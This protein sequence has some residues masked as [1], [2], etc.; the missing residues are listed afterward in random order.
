MGQTIGRAPL[1]Q[2]T[3]KFF[4]LPRSCIYDLWEAFNDIAEGFGLTIEEFQEII[5]SA[6]L[7]YLSITERQLNVETDVVFRLLDN[8]SN[9]LVDSLEFLSCF[10]LISGMT[11]EE[12]IRYIFSMYDFDESGVLT[13]D[14]MVLSFRSTLSG[15]AKLSKIDPPIESEVEA[16]VVLGFN[17][18]KKSISLTPNNNNDVNALPDM[19]GIDREAFVT[20]CL[21][22]PEVLSWIEFFDDMEEYVLDFTSKKPLPSLSLQHMGRTAVDEAVM[23]PSTGGLAY[24]DLERKGRAASRRPWENVVPLLAPSRKALDSSHPVSTLPSKHVDLEWIY[25]VNLHSSSQ[26]L[27]Y[28]ARGD[29][30]YAAGAVCVVQD[31][32]A[33]EQRHFNEHVDLVT[34]LKLFHGLDGS[35]TVA[36]GEVG[37]RPSIL[38]WDLDSRRVLATLR[39]FHR[40]GVSQVDFSPDRSRLCSLGMDLYRCVAVYDWRRGERLWSARTTADRVV[41][42]RFLS[43]SVL[44]T[45]GELHVTFWRE[46]KPEGGGEN[47]RGVVLFKRYRGVFGSHKVESQ[48][49]VGRVGETV[50]SCSDTGMLYKWEGRSVVKSVKAHTASI[51]CVHV[52][53]QGESKGLVTACSLGKVLLWNDKLELGATFNAASLGPIDPCISSVSYDVIAGKILIGFRCC[54]VFEMDAADGKNLHNTGAIV[55]AHFKPRLC[56]LSTHPTQAHLLCTVGDDKTIRIFDTNKRRQTK[57][58]LLDSKAH[59]CCFSS[60]G[61]TIVVGIGSGLDGDP[62][63]KEGA[64][65]V[66]SEEDLTLLYESRDTKSVISD[67]KFSPSGDKIVMASHD[68]CLYVYNTKK[69]VS[70]AKCRGHTGKA[71]HLDFSTNGQ[72]L[73]SNCSSGDLLFWEVES[74]ELQSPKNMKLVQWETN[75]CVNSFATQGLYDPVQDGT[76]YHK[77]CRSNARDILIAVDN[78]GRVRVVDFPCLQEERSAILDLF[79]HAKEVTN[80]SMACDDS[81]F[82]TTGGTDGCLFQWRLLPLDVNNNKDMKRDDV[83]N[84][85]L[86]SELKFEGK[87]LQKPDFYENMMNSRPIA[88]CEM[89]EGVVDISK[90]LP[91]QKTIVAP[92]RVPLEDGSEPTDSLDLEFVYG[93]ACE[94]SRQSLMYSFGGEAL[95]FSSA[96]VVL[97]NQKLRT[98][99]F[100][101]QHHGTVTALSTHKLE[102]IAASG[103]LGEVPSIRVWNC[104]TLETI[105]VLSGFHRRCINHLKF[106]PDGKYLI[107]VGQDDYHSIALYDWKNKHLISHSYSFQNK[108][109]FVDFN[110]NSSHLVQCGNEIIKFWEINGRNLQFQDAILG[111]RAKMQGFLCAGWVGGH[112]VVGTADGSIYR[113]LGHKLDSMIQAHGGAVNCISYSNDGLCSCSIDGSIKVWTRFLECRLIIEM[114]NIGSVNNNVRCIDWDFDLS[115]ILVGTAS[116]EVFEISSGDG[117]NLHQGPLLEGHGGDE[118]WGLS[119]NP[120]KDEFCTVGDD[121]YLRVWDVF[122]HKTV[123][124]VS[125]EMPARCCAFS[126]DGKQLVVGFGCPRKLSNRQFDGKWVVLDTHDYQVSHEARDSTK[127]LTDVKY[128]PNGE[129]IAIGSFDNKIYVYSVTA[130]YALNA[131]IGQHQSFITGIDFSEDNAWLRS[132]CGGYELFFFEADTGLYI[133]AAARLR[134]TVWATQTCSMTWSVQGV[135]P[136]QKDGTD[137]TACDGNLFRGEDGAVVVVG[138]N[139]GRIRLL[140]YPCT[141]SFSASKLYWTS[142]NPITRLKF[143]SGDSVLVSLSGIDKSIMQWSHKRDRDPLVAFDVLDRRGK[144]EE[145]EDDVVNLFGLNAS[146]EM[147][148][149]NDMSH[150]VSSKAWIAAMVAPSDAPSESECVKEVEWNLS[151]SHVLGLQTHVTRSS[152]RFNNYGDIVFPVSKYVCVFNKKQNSQNYYCGHLNEISCITTSKDGILCASVEKSLRPN[153]HIWDSATTELIIVLPQLHRRGV[154]SMQFSSDRKKIVSVGEDQDHSIALWISPSADWSDGKLLGWCKGDMNPTLFCSFYDQGISNQGYLLAS[155]GRFHQKFWKLNGKSINPFYAE[156]DK[157]T[158]ISTLLCGAAVGNK[159][160]SGS[161][162]GHLYIWLGK[163]LDRIVRAHELGVT[164]LSSCGVGMVSA[165]KDGIVKLWN[166]EFEHIRSFTLSEA[167]VPPLLKNVRS[168]DILL[169]PA[170]TY[171]S[172]VLAA[173]SSGEIYEISTKSGNMCL[174]HEAHYSGELWGLCVHPTDPD[175]FVTTGDDKTIRVW[176]ISQRKLLRKAVIDCSSRCVN[177][178]PDGNQLIVGMGGAADGKKQ[179]K[180]GAFLLLDAITMKPIYEGRDSRHWLPDIKFSPDGKSFATASMDHKIYIYNSESYRLKGTC[181]RHNSYIKGFDYSQDSMYIQSDSGDNEHL[182]FEGE[183][184]EYFASG[185]QL[186][187]IK[188]SEWTCLFG[189]PVQ[190]AW[191]H[192]SDV[193][194]GADC[195]PT[196]VHRSPNQKLLATGNQKGDLRLLNYPAIV[197]RAPN[198]NRGGH[199]SEVSKVRFSCD[200]SHLISLGKSDRSIIIWKIVPLKKID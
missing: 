171:I 9:N 152:V 121:S 182:Y 200:G 79:G 139:F 119:Y 66:V 52:V 126:P 190:G 98:Q 75:S 49:C 92:S 191:P 5:K 42:L 196:A 95:F 111:S 198:F 104:D 37:Q 2:G 17:A 122:T 125:L 185:S 145:D 132:N 156:Y 172:Q 10:A 134:D 120:M 65:I 143:G 19:G 94:T 116:S 24:L 178:S 162:A 23:C 129:I 118:L 115:R 167:D 91:W 61:Q 186:K 123:T 6:L 177:W 43:D 13:L 12:K 154:V 168:I 44:A 59:C 179:R 35:T 73:M 108:S 106:S 169:S 3:R 173:T 18:L 22:T 148:V 135:W 101:C 47:G 187:D 86:Y 110:P 58:S 136:P 130:S 32:L 194:S 71:M 107:S 15:L 11:P 48:N 62:E 141:T 199:V 70:K 85:I 63:R 128:S 39:G 157:K 28:S 45:C 20:Y 55:S 77:V 155:G 193:E 41:D 87:S 138:D 117:E 163:R 146:Q 56:G 102:S 29:V 112:A 16:I 124:S 192:F 30:V 103:D 137:I 183:D 166:L 1:P 175:Q 195:E 151:M 164:C 133:P 33:H 184:G 165:A 181:D 140:R 60:D 100:Y 74:G 127:W 180:D 51:Q 99:R 149:E 57:V 159:F 188:W 96:V 34:C 54:Q 174:L 36:S 189:W 14:E 153:I 90:V 82:F 46:N 68:G 113:F 40:N 176:S 197:K 76:V 147:V 38:V 170:N 4:N 83:V 89:E 105:C 67:C 109:F 88:I 26:S 31:V 161:V 93:F 114:K 21:T 150:L 142:A 25:G 84:E 131:V 72:Y 69:Y 7:E 158:K 160:V 8:D 64:F 97:M 80:V 78:Y 81:R 27:H 50:F 144:V 53:D